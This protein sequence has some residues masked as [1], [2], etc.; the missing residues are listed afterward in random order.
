MGPAVPSRW[1]TFFLGLPEP[2]R[3]CLFQHLDYTTSCN[4]AMVCRFF[5]DSVQPWKA[6]VE[7]KVAAVF[8][9]ERYFAQ[10][11]PGTCHDRDDPKAETQG[12]FGCFLCH[13]V[14]GPEHFDS[15]QPATAIMH[16]MGLRPD[17]IA[18][19]RRT[20]RACAPDKCVQ[21]AAVAGGARG[22][23]DLWLCSCRSSLIHA[24][25]DFTRDDDRRLVVAKPSRRVHLRR[26][27]VECGVQTN[28]HRTGDQ[29]TTKTGRELWLGQVESAHTKSGGREAETSTFT[30]DLKGSG[31]DSQYLSRGHAGLGEM[32]IMPLLARGYCLT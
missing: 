17:V 21:H 6:D 28:L 2:V 9:A 3:D 31:W 20:Y 13:R 22:D 26:F 24:A 4:L 14:R 32:F 23:R 16:Q 30:V 25:G 27:C 29:L 8:Q 12:N 11:F 19:S 5:A 10:H 15:E 18:R 7:D 1:M